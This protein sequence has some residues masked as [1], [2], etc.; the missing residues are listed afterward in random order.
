MLKWI[1]TLSAVAV[2]AAAMAQD[3]GKDL[4]AKAAEA[5]KQAKAITYT[6]KAYGEG[7]MKTY[8][9]QGEATVRMVRDDNKQ[10][11]VRVTG[12]GHTLGQKETEFDVLFASRSATWV[13]DA[14]KKVFEK[15]IR[16]AGRT[17]AV[18]IASEIGKITPM[19]SARAFT[20]E[21][22]AKELV[23]EAP[24]EVGKVPCDVVVVTY[25]G[26]DGQARWFLG[27]DDHLPRK[28]ERVTSG[29]YAGAM[30]IE[31]AKVDHQVELTPEQVQI[32]TPPGYERVTT[33]KKIV[34]PNIKPHG[35]VEA[36][37]PSARKRGLGVGDIA[38]DFTLPDAEGNTVSLESLHGNVVVLDFWGTWCV[39]CHKASPK[40][41]ALVDH[42]AGKPMKVV[43]LAVH[44]R[45]HDAPA[46]Y[47]KEHGYTYD[48]LLDA[49]K[50]AKQYKVRAYPTFYVIGA[51]GEILATVKRVED[52]TFEK[53]TELIERALA[54]KAEKNNGQG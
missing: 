41:Q 50:V 7:A 10:W 24:A 48:L 45:D 1:T 49:D 46:K 27:Q 26:R 47:M 17:P 16:E 3:N 37:H 52:D 51:D 11:L 21:L 23:V 18:G 30:V 8:A 14:E 19:L 34:K 40:L 4:F 6:A 35:P 54:K 33:L 44:E 39:P 28:V 12:K 15:P 29:A 13:D 20:K 32:P 25:T 2:C 43:G 9:P 31:L 38:P 53:M 22:G 42:F 5:V 36:A